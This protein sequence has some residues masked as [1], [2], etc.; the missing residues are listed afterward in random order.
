MATLVSPYGNVLNPLVKQLILRSRVW[1]FAVVG[2]D[3]FVPLHPPKDKIAKI[4]NFFFQHFPQCYCGK[5][6]PPYIK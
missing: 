6:V 3:C 2:V 4:L 5:G 1:Q